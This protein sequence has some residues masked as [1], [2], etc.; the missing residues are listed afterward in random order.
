M[1]RGA[2]HDEGKILFIGGGIA[3]FTNVASTFKGI[4]RALTDFKSQLKAHNVKI[5]VRRAG[6]NYQEGLRMIR[7]VGELLELDMH[8][9]GP[10]MF[11]TG[12]VPLALC[13]DSKGLQKNAN[14][15]K[16]VSVDLIGIG[17]QESI[18]DAQLN[19]P[20]TPILDTT[21]EK[22]VPFHNET[23]ALIYG[24]QPRAVQGM[25]D[26]DYMCKRSRPSV[27]AMV[28]PFGGHH[29]QKFYWGTKECLV[30]V[31]TSLDEAVKK[32]PDVTVVVNFSSFRS[33]LDSCHDIF[34]ITQ[35]KTIAII[36]EGVPELRSRQILHL[37][38]NLGVL[39]IGPATV[40]GIKPG[41]F[42]IGNTGGMMDNIV[43][44]K[45]YRAGSVAY[46]SKSGGMSNELNNIISQCTD[47]VYEGVAIGGDRYPGS[48][49]ID[50]MLRF[51][52][53]P[54]A[55]IIVLLGEVGGVEEYSISKALKDGRIKKPVVAWC[56]GTCSKMFSTDVLLFN[57]GTIWT[58]WI[59]CRARH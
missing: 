12:I 24:M 2:P 23:R 15:N 16:A 35:I 4:I 57:L 40:G 47:G 28:Y 42:K 13:G 10:E 8:V 29:I 22:S 36:A 41:S 9:F 30:P 56:I 43:S 39:I 48:T 19:T 14:K 59:F 25:L 49:F 54:L 20:T 18:S 46:V 11:I 34:K 7:E 37:A 6:P 31:Y 45:L 38:K 5:Y 50:H 52:N 44:S 26:F 53:D 33:V 21:S 17:N 51:E 32:F 3:N 55:K 1:T 27:A 58:C